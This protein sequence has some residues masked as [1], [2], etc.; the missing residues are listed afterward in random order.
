MADRPQQ[1][2]HRTLSTSAP[3]PMPPARV[4]KTPS[5]HS[6]APTSVVG[7]AVVGDGVD[8]AGKDGAGRT[9]GASDTE[10]S[11]PNFGTGPA[12]RFRLVLA[13]DTGCGAPESKLQ[14]ALGAVGAFRRC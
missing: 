13:V 5:R 1:P 14:L 4:C 3:L 10:R 12:S 8:S 11:F 7:V 6:S 2:T 9:P